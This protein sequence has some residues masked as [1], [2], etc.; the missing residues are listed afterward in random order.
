MNIATIRSYLM[1]ILQ[2][3]GVRF[4]S[5]IPFFFF[6]CIPLIFIGLFLGVLTES[7]IAAL[8]VALALSIF[9]TA[10]IYSGKS[11]R[12]LT[13][14]IF[15][16]AS[17]FWGRELWDEMINFPDK[18]IVE[19]S[20]TP[21]YP[22][23]SIHT[24]RLRSGGYVICVEKPETMDDIPRLDFVIRKYDRNGNLLDEVTERE[25]GA[26]RNL[27]NPDIISCAFGRGWG[28]K[29][30]KDFYVLKL[31][32]VGS[33]FDRHT[34]TIKVETRAADGFSETLNFFL[35]PDMTP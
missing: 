25:D 13:V 19:F 14:A 10:Y 5:C 3:L 29:D 9:L 12:H 11:G 21:P 15:I 31:F 24:K 27:S 2:T 6:F 33:I 18:P 17:F 20:L 8:I 28:H 30:R 34:D 23:I 26:L 1:K 35:A 16:V 32:Y 4:F 7:S 22:E